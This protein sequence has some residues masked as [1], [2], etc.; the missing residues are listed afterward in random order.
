MGKEMT[1]VTNRTAQQVSEMYPVIGNK[2]VLKELFEAVMEQM[3][4][5]VAAHVVILDNVKGLLAKEQMNNADIA[6]YTKEDVWSQ[7]QTVM[8]VLLSQ[9]WNI[10]QSSS[11]KNN[12]TGSF[13]SNSQMAATDLNAYFSKRKPTKY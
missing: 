5:I 4:R 7:V 1:S 9:Y 12:S 11:N 2:N 8:Q 6:L 10:N 3:R 13:S